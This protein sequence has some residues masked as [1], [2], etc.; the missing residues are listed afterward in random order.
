[1]FK[2]IVLTLIIL[3]VSASLSWAGGWDKKKGLDQITLSGELLCIGCTL[4]KL[5]GA[6]AQCD[7]YTHH[8]IGFKTADG[9]LWSI[10]DN[11]KGHDVIN[12]HDLVENK[13]AT[14]TGWIYPIANFIEIDDIKVDGVTTAEIQKAGWEEDQLIAKGLLN[15]KVGETPTVEAH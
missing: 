11:A 4:K 3:V 10:V 9:T 1:M 6:N 2:K 13:K 14:I 8:A 15:R 7:L 5:D 12:S